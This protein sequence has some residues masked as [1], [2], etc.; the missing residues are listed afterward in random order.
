MA[1]HQRLVTEFEPLVENLPE[2]VHIPLARQRD[3]HQVQRDHALV[4]SAVEL[5][6]AVRVAPRRQGGTAT[7]HRKAVALFQLLHLLFADVVRHQPLGGTFRRLPGQ[8]VVFAVLIDVVLFKHIDQLR[9]SRGDIDASIVLDA[10]IPLLEDLFDDDGKVFFLLLAFRFVQVHENGYERS[11]PV[12]GHQRDDLILDGLDAAGNFVAHTFFHD[13][14]ELFHADRCSGEFK[15][16]LHFGADTV[17]G[18]LNERSKV[19]QSDALAAV[20]VAGDLSDD[21]RGDV[22]GG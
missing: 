7:H 9:E 13:C 16:L 6:V 17:A 21:L 15:L 3:I 8:V 22:A 11:L 10:L 2:A 1:A 12:G 14:V 19:G 5:V 18:D 4:E 20:L